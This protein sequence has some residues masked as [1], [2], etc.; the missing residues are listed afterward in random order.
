[1][2]N[3]IVIGLFAS[4]FF[5]GYL[6]LK[7]IKNQKKVKGQFKLDKTLFK[8]LLTM[9]NG[10]KKTALRLLRRVSQNNPDKSYVWCHEKVI[11][12]LKRDRRY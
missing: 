5:L 12:D 7:E 3:I 2:G 9:L 6:L 10:D 1:M 8:K 4:L 11:R